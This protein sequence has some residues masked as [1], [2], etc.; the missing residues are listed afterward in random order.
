[1]NKRKAITKFGVICA[2]VILGITLCFAQFTVPFTTYRYVGFIGAIQSKMGIDLNGGVLAVFNCETKNGSGSVSDDEISATIRRLERSLSSKGY[3]E[4][5]ITRQGDKIRIEVPG[6]DDTEEIFKAIGEP[7]ELTFQN[8]AGLEFLT[9]KDI[10]KVETYQNQQ[11]EWGVKLTFTSEGGVKFREQIKDESNSVIHILRNGEK[12]SSPTIQ[13]RDA[14]ADD[15]TVI[16]SAAYKTEADAAIFKL[17]IE[18]GMFEVRLTAAETSVIPP[19]LGTNALKGGILAL[20]I[21]LI[22]IF[23]F[24]FLIYGDLGLLSNLSLIV[25]C[26]IFAASLAVVGSVQLTLPGI[27]G[28]V[29]ALGMAVDANVIIFERIKD[30]YRT[31]KKMSVAVETGFNKSIMTIVDANVTSVIAS[32]VLFM[33]GTGAIKGFAIT[34]LLGVVI[35]MFCSLIITRSF[36]KLYLYINRDNAKRLRLGKQGSLSQTLTPTAKP[37]SRKLNLGGKQ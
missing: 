32:G 10:K 27:A 3:V 15:T 23:I 2:L 28:I 1:M 25:F 26:I 29:L 35:S 20:V 33:F 21:G 34:L 24:M 19:T 22:F 36:A 7:A 17:E 6:M 11:Y 18:S 37:R 12:F 4:A 13:S 31:G 16:T 30:E 8:E 5:A 14:G 9:G